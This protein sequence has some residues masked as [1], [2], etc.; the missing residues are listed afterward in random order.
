MARSH[1]FLI[2]AAACAT[3]ALLIALDV[4]TGNR[5]AWEDGA[6]LAFVLSFLP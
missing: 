3:V 4:F 5:Q 6:L 2:A 1:L